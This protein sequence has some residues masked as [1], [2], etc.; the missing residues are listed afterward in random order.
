MSPLG[1]EERGK[2]LFAYMNPISRWLVRK[3]MPKAM[4]MGAA[5]HESGG[6]RMGSD[7]AA[8]V[9]NKFNQ[10]WDAPNVFVTDASAFPSS[11]ARGTTLTVM[12]LTARACEH[13]AQQ[14]RNGKFQIDPD[15]QAA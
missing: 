7:P 4:I 12:A 13:L 3:M 6:A 1:M 10:C 9:L 14:L 11:G 5:I 2:G 15:S 8:S